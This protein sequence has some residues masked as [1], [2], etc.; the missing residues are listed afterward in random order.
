MNDAPAH[1]RNPGW[2]TRNVFNG[3]VSLFTRLGLSVWGSR[4]LEVRGRKTGQPRRVP[5]N[6]LTV[7]DTRYLVAPRGETQW[8]R[9]LRAAGDGV[10]ILGRKRQRFSAVELADADKRPVLR[11]YL[12]RWKAEVGVFFDGVS[13]DSSD[14]EVDRIAA[15]H[16]VFRLTIG[17]QAS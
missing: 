16:P 3:V 13:A 7:E 15:R 10:L 6:L 5:V 9:N 12:K 2:F 11:A 4:V 14:A 17:D 1:Y 8:V